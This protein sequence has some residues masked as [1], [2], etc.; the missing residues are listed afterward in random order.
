MITKERYEMEILQRI[1][2]LRIQRGWSIYKLAEES[3]ITQSTLANM[4]AR[5]TMPSISTL[6]ML[7]DAFGISLSE[8]FEYDNKQLSQEDFLT[9][10]HYKKLSQSNKNIIRFLIQAMLNEKDE[11]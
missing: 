9:I 10:S 8:F 4:F 2:D 7:C 5:K 1:N 3:G 11:Q 6:K